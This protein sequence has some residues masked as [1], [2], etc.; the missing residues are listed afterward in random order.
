M[1]KTKIGF[2][3]GSNSMK[4][5]VLRGDVI[6]V[7]EVRLPENLVEGDNIVMPN[8]FSQ[9]LKET[10]K[11][12][13][14]PKAAAALVLP[15]SHS[16]CRLVTMPKMTQQ[17]LIMNL[18]YEFSEFIQGVP[19]QY[20]CD[21]AVC[22]RYDGEDD[23]SMPMM[24]AVAPKAKLAEYAGIFYK[25]GINLKTILPQEMSLVS[26]SRKAWNDNKGEEYCFVDLGEQRTRITVVWRD[27]VQATRQIPFGGGHINQ[28]AADELGIDKFLAN[29]YKIAKS[30][31]IANMPA[32]Y[33]MCER[34]A[35][36]ILKVVN[37]YRFTYQKSDL[38]GIYVVGGGAKFEP[39]IQAITEQVS[40]ELLNAVDI[41]PNKVQNASTALFAIGAA[42]EVAR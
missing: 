35:V 22:E 38:K 9:F 42:M 18:P 4:I 29:S 40:M 27:R 33:E 6:R 32:V 19:D 3:I 26:L 10:R 12:L 7:E 2:D 39:L 30:N 14:L 11:N 31:D 24:A 28:I 5:A 1:E 21:Y 37:F 16:I 36:E 41:L 20:F 8:T 15:A 13:K 17:Q 34:I 23:E 25:A